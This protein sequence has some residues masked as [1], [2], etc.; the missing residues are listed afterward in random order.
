MVDSNTSRMVKT[1]VPNV[2]K[3]PSG[4]FLARVRGKYGSTSDSFKSMAG[5]RKWL[6]EAVTSLER[7]T[8]VIH[9]GKLMT[10]VEAEEAKNPSLTINEAVAHFT[11]SADCKVKPGHLRSI[12]TE[13]GECKLNEINKAVIV[14]FLD[15]QCEGLAPATRNRYLSTISSVLKYCNQRDWIEGNPASLVSKQSE[16]GNARDRVITIE[17]ERALQ[18]AFDAGDAALGDIFALLMLTGARVRE[19]TTLT[20][21]DVDIARSTIRL[22]AGS[23]KARKSRTLFLAGRA[24]ERMQARAHIRPISDDALVFVS[25]NGREV[26]ATKAFR[27]YADSI[28]Y[29]WFIAHLCRHTF[30]SRAAATPGMTVSRL[31]ELCGWSSWA[32]ASRYAHAMST[33]TH[34]VM[35]SI[36]AQYS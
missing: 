16:S 14:G 20:W 11:R 2:Y 21:R 30:A 23:T 12:K 25:A 13:L 34:D 22:S 6:R 1:S 8:H 36:A 5:A 18:A 10:C 15:R 7:Q 35:A 17:E 31:C 24:A 28:G 27:T 9:A 32:M 29:E 19:I 4:L 33:D 26:D 3:L